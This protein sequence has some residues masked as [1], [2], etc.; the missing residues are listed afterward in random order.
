MEKK[1]RKIK[2][3]RDS[4]KVKK[5]LE[6]V[7]KDAQNN[8]NLM[9]SV[10]EAVKQYATVGEITKVLKEVYGEYQEPIYF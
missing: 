1:R 4:Q 8:S 7:K 5:C 2:D 3:K 6:N 9:P 10:I